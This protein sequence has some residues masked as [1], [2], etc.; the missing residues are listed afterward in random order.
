MSTLAEIEAAAKALPPE[1]KAKLLEF[2]AGT[3]TRPSPAVS[4]ADRSPGSHAGAWDVAAD[5]DAPLPDEF[6]TGA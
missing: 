5:F 1:E 4:S 6:W 3:V 2:L